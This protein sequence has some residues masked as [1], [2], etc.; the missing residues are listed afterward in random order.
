MQLYGTSCCYSSVLVYDY[1]VTVTARSLTV[2]TVFLFCPSG[3]TFC[4]QVP[5][6]TYTHSA[7]N[8]TNQELWALLN[9]IHLDTKISAKER[10]RL[11]GQFYQAHPEIFNQYFGES[12]VSVL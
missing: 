8:N 5:S 6:R 9:S 12:A 3:S 11:L 7:K 4:Q 10:K 2:N 1:G